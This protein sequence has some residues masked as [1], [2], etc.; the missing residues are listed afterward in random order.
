MLFSVIIPLFNKENEIKETLNSVFGQTYKDFEVIVIDDGSTDSGLSLVKALDFHSLRVFSQA[1]AGVSAARNKGISEAKGDFCVFL[2][3]DDILL[4]EHLANLSELIIQC[5]DDVFYSTAH[6]LKE[7]NILYPTTEIKIN[8]VIQGRV[9]SPFQ[10]FYKGLALVNSSTACIRRKTLIDFNFRFPEGFSRGEDLFLW[11]SLISRFGIVHTNIPTV[12]I[13]RDALSR[14]AHRELNVV[15]A[16]FFYLGDLIDDPHLNRVDKYWLRKF[17]YK[18]ARNTILFSR[19]VGARFIES[20]LIKIFKKNHWHQ[21][22]WIFCFLKILPNV[23]F[24]FSYG[25]FYRFRGC[26]K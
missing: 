4:P 24:R 14:S 19:V 9:R 18:S 25:I 22:Y 2:D 26:L 17:F 11:I 12:V 10:E 3:G 21:E 15:P 13:N 6:L 23:F 1:N 20:E 8:A 7:N 16:H 5:P